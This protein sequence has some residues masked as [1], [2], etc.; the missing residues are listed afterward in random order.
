MVKKALASAAVLVL[1]VARAK[2][3]GATRCPIAV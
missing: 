2:K 3:E 1:L